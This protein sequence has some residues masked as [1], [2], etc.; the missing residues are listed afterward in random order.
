MSAPDTH[1]PQL[2]LRRYHAVSGRYEAL[3]DRFEQHTLGLFTRHHM[4]SL[5]Y[6]TPEN[7]PDVLVYLLRHDGDP[8]ENWA[9]FQD[10]PEWQRVKE[11]TTADGPLTVSIESTFLRETRLNESLP[12]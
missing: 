7:E 9:A 8:T 4:T 10:D 11:L 1:P 2:E 6:W 5:G 3:L 12:A